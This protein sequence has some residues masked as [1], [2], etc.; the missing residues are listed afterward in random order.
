MDALP[1]RPPPLPRLS[2]ADMLRLTTVRNLPNLTKIPLFLGLMV[3]A[4]WVAWTTTSPV[5]LWTAYVALGYLWM[6]IVTFMHDGTHDTLFARPWL[7]TAFGVVA[8]IPIGVSFIAFQR[9]H[10]EHHRYNRS[11]RDPDAFTMGRRGVADFVLFYAYMIAGALLSFVHFNLLYPL[12]SFNGR[13]WAMH[14]FETALKVAAYAALIAWA[15]EHGVL[16]KTLA[17][18]LIPIFIFSLFNSIRF[19]AE[20]YNTPWDQGQ[21]LGTRTIRSNPVHAFFWNNINWHIGHHIY[22]KVPWY[23]LVELH[24]LLR[25]GIEEQGAIIDRGYAAVFFDALCHGPETPD[26][27]RARLDARRA[28]ARAPQIPPASAAAL[29]PA[30]M[31]GREAS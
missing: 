13:Q 17:L 2:R 3:A 1:L 16:D 7:N 10:L 6:G 14:L 11:P 5:V 21:L 8:M 20:H 19:I 12:K 22:P 29:A 31:A 18:W 26:R 23:N 28:S 9:D 25:A 30:E 24:R 15:R 27:L 4:G